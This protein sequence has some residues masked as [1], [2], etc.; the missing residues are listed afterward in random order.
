MRHDDVTCTRA[1]SQLTI[2]LAR[3]CMMSHMEPDSNLCQM[4]RLICQSYAKEKWVF[5]PANHL[6]T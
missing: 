5:P 2:W 3:H 1:Q 6:K 4:D